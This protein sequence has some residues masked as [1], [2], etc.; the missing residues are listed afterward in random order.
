[1][2][3]Y[4][5]SPP[6]FYA[7]SIPEYAD[8]FLGPGK[9]FYCPTRYATFQAGAIL[10]HTISMNRPLN[11]SVIMFFYECYDPLPHGSQNI[12]N[13]SKD[14][15]EQTT[16]IDYYKRLPLHELLDHPFFKIKK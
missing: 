11:L 10:Y 7:I 12:P 13:S 8:R 4:L 1:M 3:Q 14:F 6:E 16:K 2:R 15:I 9:L 5:T